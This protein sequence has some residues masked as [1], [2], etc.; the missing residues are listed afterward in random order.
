[1]RSRTVDPKNYSC[2][3]VISDLHIPYHHQDAFRFLKL[4]RD[5]YKPDKIVNIGDEVDN[6]GISFHNTD[7]DLLSP[8][9][10][11][12][13]TRKHINKLERIF[14]EMS[15]VDSNH[16][17][18]AYRRMKSDGIPIEFLKSYNEILEVGDDWTWHSELILKSDNRDIYF[19]HQFGTNIL[20]QAEQMG[21]NCVQGHYHSKFEV[22][23]T[24][25]PL[26]LHYGMTVGCLIDDKSLAF[27]YN[28]LQTKR[29]IIG[30]AVIVEGEPILIP[31]R[32]GK[33]R[34]WNGRI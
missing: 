16:G 7:P 21:M 2:I 3:L 27:E 29:P 28:R 30:C 1:M 11:L 23:Y 6:H 32:L 10:E 5:T 13:E 34:R 17:S 26:S 8:G 24:S 15:L 4:V 22:S 19:M 9:H 33:N 25:S 18:L 20:K 12:K 31:M 14:P